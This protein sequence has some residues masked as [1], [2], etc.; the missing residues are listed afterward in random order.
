MIAEEARNSRQRSSWMLNAPQSKCHHFDKF[1]TIAVFTRERFVDLGRATEVHKQEANKNWININ[2]E[3]ESLPLIGGRSLFK[4]STF[5]SI[6]DESRSKMIKAHIEVRNVRR[7]GKFFI[8]CYYF[9]VH[10]ETSLFEA[11]DLSSFHRSIAEYYRGKMSHPTKPH[12][13][14]YRL[15]GGY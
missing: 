11:F 13:F 8:V 5:E 10:V 14:V 15:S 3:H 4:F 1:P 12:K 6:L 9:I 7:F 2:N